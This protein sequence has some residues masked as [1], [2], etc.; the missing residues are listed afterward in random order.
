MSTKQMKFD[1]DAHNAFMEGID[2]MAR[3]V[4]VT[5]GP[6]GRN[7]VVQKSFG[8]PSV[9]K[10]GVSVSREVELPQA[11]QNMG[12]QM[13]HQVA[14]K[15]ADLAG[16]GTTTAT[17][18]ANA[19]FKSGLR[20]VTSGANAVAIQRGINAAAMEACSFIESMA[21]TCEGRDDLRKIA[22]VSANHDTS[23]GDIISE[24]LDTVGADGVVEVEEGKTSETTLD[25]VEG[26]AFD[27]GYLSP[28]FM[29]DPKSTE[30]VLEDAA[31]LI[32]EKK[33]SN[34]AD[35]LPLLNKTATAGKQLLIIA[36]D[37]E[38]EALA[39]LVV[40]RLRGVLQIC[41]VKAPG[42]GERRKAM[43]G[44]IAA[45]TGG[46]FL[47]ED[48]G[49][50]LEDV[51][52]DEL[53]SARRI[54]VT[55]DGTTV[56][57][58]A[59]T[60]EDIDARAT[61]IRI[62]IEKSTSDYD[63]E[64]L[65]ERLAKLTGGVAIIAV[66]GSTEVEMKER[67]DRVDD[68]LSASRAAAKEGYV[69]GGGVSFIRA[70]DYLRSKAESI[71]GDER[72]GYEILAD[73]IEAPAWHIAENCGIDGDVVVEKI[74]QGEGDFGYDA[75]EDTYCN[76]VE[77][78]IIDPTLVVCVSMKNAASVSGLLLTTDVAITDLGDDDAPIQNAVV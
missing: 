18:L 61:Q 37:V 27:K 48:L 26:M 34:L 10:D 6:S 4:S 44:D 64:K 33:I 50:N 14:K 31:I 65:Q 19:I 2:Q 13:V 32:H 54:V 39:A 78:G 43:L 74:R 53:G 38:N 77:R 59:G 47:S 22:T 7:V 68:A 58:G 42:F 30:C 51:E 24:A 62:Q 9:T 23:I 57:R 28:Y 35:L 46:L 5:M 12:A 11:F 63:R 55:K 41:A 40:N 70:Q 73:A 52:L 29:T 72:I 17:V 8:S 66:G 56:I 20:H 15:T 60:K 21:R 25:Y 45:M 49:R 76:L 1:T 3:A 67:K 75:S 69:P 36:E 16:D 71:N